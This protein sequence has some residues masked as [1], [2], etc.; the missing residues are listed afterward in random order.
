MDAAIMPTFQDGG[1]ARSSTFPIGGGARSLPRKGVVRN[2]RAWCVH[3]VF[4]HLMLYRS[5]SDDCAKTI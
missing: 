5:N 2:L 1:V 4:K 3:F